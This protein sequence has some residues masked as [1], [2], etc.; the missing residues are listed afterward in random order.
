MKKLAIIVFTICLSASAFAD[1]IWFRPEMS[2]N[3]FKKFTKEIGSVIS[4]DPG[5]P[6]ESLGVTGFRIGAEATI[7]STS[8]VWDKA[9]ED[10]K[11]SDSLILYRLHVQKGLP[12]KLDVGAMIGS[13]ANSDFNYAGVSASYAILEGTAVTPAITLR[14]AYSQIFGHDELEAYN[15][16]IGLFISKGFVMLK[17]YAGLMGTVTHAEEQTSR[18]SLS[19]ETEYGVKGILG[20]E[21]TP[22]P[23]LRLNAELGIGELTQVSFRA[24][25]YF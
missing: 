5:S 17:P 7:S 19:S 1:D 2:Q 25:I 24:G 16:N 11:F 21:A 3:D 20:L 6:V 9:A 22:F 10:G 12:G 13:A 8:S 15:A 23:F 18:V 4:F 14:G